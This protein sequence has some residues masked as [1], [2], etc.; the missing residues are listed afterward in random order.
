MDV[1]AIVCLWLVSS[2]TL[3]TEPSPDVPEVAAAV[4]EALVE[5]GSTN[6]DNF[7]LKYNVDILSPV[8]KHAEPEVC[9]CVCVHVYLCLC[10][11]GYRGV[12]VCAHVS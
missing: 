1:C 5:V 10:G 8:V 4:K 9:V 2:A 11:C 6:M 3:V 7:E 12:C